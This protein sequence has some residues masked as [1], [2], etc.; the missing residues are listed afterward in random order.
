MTRCSSPLCLRARIKDG[1]YCDRH[2]SELQ[3]QAFAPEWV[4]RAQQ[5]RLPVRVTA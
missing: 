3:T 2:T 4:R 1:A 5:H